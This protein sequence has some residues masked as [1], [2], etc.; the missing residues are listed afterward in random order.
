MQ[1]ITPQAA[2]RTRVARS[3]IFL[4]LACAAMLSWSGRQANAADADMRVD[5][6]AR[7]CVAL[8]AMKVPAGAFALPIG[9]AIVTEALLIAPD[10]TTPEYC[11]VRATIA[12]AQASDPSILYQVNLPSRWN[13]KTVLY[14]GG[15]LNGVLVEA[16][17]A[18]K[19][20]DGLTPP[21]ARGYATYGSDSG[22]QTPGDSFY[23]NAQAAANYS[24]E[25]VKRT[26]DL[27][28]ALVDVYYGKAAR[29]NYQ[30][31]GSKGGQ[32]GL[33]AV[34]RYYA[35]FDGVVSY[36]PAA[37][38]QSLGLA[39]NRLWHYAFN[40]PG[41]A[42]NTAKQALL[43]RAVL[44]ACDTLDG[45]ADGLV[46]DTAGCHKAFNVNSLRCP[47]GVDAGNACLSDPQ[48]AALNAA[49]TPLYFA[50]P[51]PNG[52]ES[53]GPWPAFILGDLQ[54]WFGDGAAGT[55]Q[56]FYRA[57][58]VR[59]EA[60]TSAGLDYEIWRKNVEPR[61]K[62]FDASNPDID[63]YKARGAKLLIVQGTTDML[64]PTAMTTRYF[65]DLSARY[66]AQELRQFVRYYVVPGYGHGRGAFT[67]QWD[68]LAALDTWVET[69]NAPE[70]PVVTDLTE[71]TRGRT[72]PLCEYPRWPKY[73]GTGS[74]D[75]AESFT[76][77]AN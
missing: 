37:Q 14:G 17:G 75:R 22:H 11:R 50:F 13:F 58:S 52:V 76:C 23:Q 19:G 20:G 61:A 5:D 7:R 35:D 32:E 56:G 41:G 30:I 3:V 16:T 9:S 1:R 42:L 12:A 25:A 18:F 38:S 54:M 47:D 69:G 55:Q 10:S 15:G 60:M 27:T 57:A 44:A 71:Q 68:S 72:R 73:S 70:R 4:V 77:V 53:V 36:Y 64:V 74:E 8:G 51:M 45:A 65:K 49:A 6:A 29:R 21:L 2:G 67:V 28:T 48:I 66:G 34:Q 39:W 40:T 46:S 33:Q 59:P 26:K 62:V 24:H 43:A 31:G 63:G